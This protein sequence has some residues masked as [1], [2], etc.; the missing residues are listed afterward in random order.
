MRQLKVDL[1]ELLLAFDSSDTLEMTWYLNLQTGEVMVV[2][3][4]IR[5][6]LMDVYKELNQRGVDSII[7]FP[8]AIQGFPEQVWV[9]EAL[10]EADQVEKGLGQTFLTVPHDPS[11]ETWE[12]MQDFA[13]TIANNRLRNDLGEVL[14]GPKPFRRFK[15]LLDRHPVEREAWF[16]FKNERLRKRVVAW[17]NEE[18]IE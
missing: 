7:D 18:D 13:A 17:L 12:D 2:S 1:A 10:I 11:G 15:D 6:V 3:D 8:T 14:E 9:K 16:K 5:R 4:E